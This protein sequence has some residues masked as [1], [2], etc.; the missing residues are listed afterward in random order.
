MTKRSEITKEYCE[1][2]S[3]ANNTEVAR[4]LHKNYPDLFRSVES[5]RQHVK[6]F[7]LNRTDSVNNKDLLMPDE[8]ILLDNYR[9]SKSTLEKECIRAGASV[10]DAERYWYK[11]KHISILFK[12]KQRTLEDLKKEMMEGMSNYSP[13]FPK[14]VRKKIKD[15]HCLVIDPAD[16]HIGKLASAY[17]TGDSYNVK[18]ATE[19]V[20][21]G[22][23][24]ILQ[25][26]SGFEIDQIVLI[27]GNDILHTD[28]A[29]RTTTSGTPQDTDGQWYDN[30]LIA[31]QL[32]VNV[33]TK[34]LGIAK[35]HVVHNV[36]NHDYMTGWFLAQIVQTWFRKCKDITFDCDMKHRKA[37][38]YHDNL[39]GTTHGDGAKQSDLN[40]LLA[41]EFPMAWSKTKFRYIY[42]HHVHHK[43]SKDLIGVT[44]ESSRSASGTD[45]WHHRNGY[46]GAV[47][48]IEAYLHHKTQGQV[49]RFSHIFK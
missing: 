9:E 23:D 28:N 43:S 8:I 34:L 22:I 5:A 30:F 48:A 7:R 24:G 4:A 40:S 39:I 27:I 11:Q 3:K 42:T 18:I 37:F 10:E 16:I 32:Y 36:S 45:G 29:K 14:F 12:P 26:A 44:V 35:V 13:S 21:Q 46:T 47:K 25:K 38:I 49:A 1:K 20:M 31:Q 19:R 41:H 17:E 33:I 15:G 2:L 6:Q